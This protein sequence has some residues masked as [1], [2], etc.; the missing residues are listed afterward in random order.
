M[1]CA[2]DVSVGALEVCI[3]DAAGGLLREVTLF[4]IYRGAGIQTGCKSVA[5]SLVL[6][7]DDRSLKSEEADA[8]MQSI[9]S[10][11]AEKLGA[12]LR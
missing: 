9:V 2:E 5:F 10:A 12:R 7:A 6:R 1:V 4:D 8:T 11:L 3:R